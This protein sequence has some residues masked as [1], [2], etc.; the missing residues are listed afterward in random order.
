MFKS[1]GVDSGEGLVA[2]WSKMMKQQEKA[3]REKLLAETW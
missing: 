1:L 3:E 2:R